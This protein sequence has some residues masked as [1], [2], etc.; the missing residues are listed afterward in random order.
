MC[1]LSVSWKKKYYNFSFAFI[2]NRWNEI[3]RRSTLLLRNRKF[4]TWKFINFVSSHF[5]INKIFFKIVSM[6][7]TYIYRSTCK[8]VSSIFCVLLY[9]NPWE[10]TFEGVFFCRC[11]YPEVVTWLKKNNRMKH[12][13]KKSDFY[14]KKPSQKN[15]SVCWW[16]GRIH[17]NSINDSTCIGWIDIDL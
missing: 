15:S 4:N 13:K 5:Q 10:F 7:M 6:F 1:C 11:S 2:S 12:R 17:A 16:K 14:Y 9:L 3:F 8:A